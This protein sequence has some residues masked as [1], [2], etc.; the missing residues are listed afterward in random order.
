M[1][2]TWAQKQLE[3]TDSYS[4]SKAFKKQDQGLWIETTVFVL[5]LTTKRDEDC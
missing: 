2:W 1:S 5:L 4:K 3:S